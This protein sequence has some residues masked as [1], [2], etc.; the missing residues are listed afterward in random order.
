MGFFSSRPKQRGP[1][2]D[3]GGFG[4][5]LVLQEKKVDAELDPPCGPESRWIGFKRKIS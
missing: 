3:R 5:N 4:E 2:R 1:I